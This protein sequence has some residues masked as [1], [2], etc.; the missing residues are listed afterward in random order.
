MEFRE[1]FTNNQVVELVNSINY[2][3]R[4]L[5]AKCNNALKIKVASEVPAEI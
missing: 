3:H 4:Q 2:T 1:K 5:A